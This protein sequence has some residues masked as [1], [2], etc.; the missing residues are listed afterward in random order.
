[1][2]SLRKKCPLLSVDEIKY[3][4]ELRSSN[5]SMTQRTKTTII[6]FI[7][8]S[9]LL[10]SYSVINHTVLMSSVCHGNIKVTENA[11]DSEHCANNY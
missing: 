2:F 3:H 8:S 11:A 1:M 6:D 5:S 10:L 7:P 4:T 9:L